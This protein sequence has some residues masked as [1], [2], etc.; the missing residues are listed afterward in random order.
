MDRQE[1]AN[2]VSLISYKNIFYTKFYLKIKALRKDTC[3]VG[4]TLKMKKDNEPEKKEQLR[5]ERNNHLK[6]PEEARKIRI[7]DF[8]TATKS[9]EHEYLSFSLEKI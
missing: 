3:N 6:I 4:D 5:Q 1:D 2:P 9:E 8:S 7:D